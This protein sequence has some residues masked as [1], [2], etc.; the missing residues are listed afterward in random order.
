MRCNL[1]ISA[2]ALCGSAT[3]TLGQVTFTPIG[4]LPGDYESYATSVSR[5]GLTVVG[6]SYGWGHE[7]AIRWTPTHGMQDLGL[8]PNV[9]YQ[10]IQIRPTGV[11]D[12]GAVVVG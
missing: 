2:L 11:S 1:P 6:W 7:H 8:I 3:I 10:Q 9:P 4:T 5:D 12:D